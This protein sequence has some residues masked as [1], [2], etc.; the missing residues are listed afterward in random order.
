MI[1][2]PWDQGT[3]IGRPKRKI[4]TAVPMTHRALPTEESD[5]KKAKTKPL[6]KES[7]EPV[8]P[9]STKAG[10]RSGRN[11]AEKL[12]SS[13]HQWRALSGGDGD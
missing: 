12:A 5:E 1:G 8:E 2:V 9:T 7:E 3:T 13:Q 6:E 4:E 11:A 10:H